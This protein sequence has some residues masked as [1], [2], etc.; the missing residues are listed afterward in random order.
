MTIGTLNQSDDWKTLANCKGMDVNLFF[1]MYE[2]STEVQLKVDSIC[3]GCPVK[4]ECY[5]YAIE[6]GL[7]SGVFGKRYI[8]PKH[9]ARNKKR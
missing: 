2:E 3:S 9:K 6:N 7:E 4:T 1:G 8:Q 5:E